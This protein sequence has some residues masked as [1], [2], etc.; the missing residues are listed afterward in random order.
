MRRLVVLI[1]FLPV[2]V[3]PLN[4]PE[5]LGEEW[6]VSFRTEVL[7]TGIV[8]IEIPRF[9]DFKTIDEEI[10]RVVDEMWNGWVDE[11]VDNAK[12]GFRTS[13]YLSF[14][15][16]RIDDRVMSIVFEDYAYLGGAHGM[17]KRVAVNYDVKRGRIL[18]SLSDVFEGDGWLERVNERIKGYFKNVQTIAK[19]KGINE[20]FGGFYITKYG[21]VIFFQLYEY[22]P[23]AVGY[24]EVFIPSSF[25]GL[26][27]DLFTRAS[28]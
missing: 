3:L 1:T 26:R 13:Y 21:I 23:Y 5:V 15:I 18:R 28:R 22:T 10:E 9:E 17:G 7:D 14:E 8:H 19:F 24:P 25:E 12:S 4:I 2:I 27:K 6:I 16:K 11:L 20:K